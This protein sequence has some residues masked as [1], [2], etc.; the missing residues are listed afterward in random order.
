MYRERAQLHNCFNVIFVFILNLENTQQ[1]FYALLGIF[2]C[3]VVWFVSIFLSYFFHSLV[4]YVVYFAKRVLLFSV[5]IL[6]KSNDPARAMPQIKTKF[7]C[8]PSDIMPN[9]HK[10]LTYATHEHEHEPTKNIALFRMLRAWAQSE[11]ERDHIAQPNVYLNPYAH[12][13][14]AKQLQ[15]RTRT[16]NRVRIWIFEQQ[17]P[18]LDSVYCACINRICSQNIRLF[19]QFEKCECVFNIHGYR[20]PV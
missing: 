14:Q 1:K 13:A 20:V 18:Q 2:V 19:S 9:K 6:T 3:A 12:C 5:I 10:T 16:L 15:T 7:I 17:Q 4:L 11:R 8:M